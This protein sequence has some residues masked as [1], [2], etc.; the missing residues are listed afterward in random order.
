MP[1]LS[2]LEA[3]VLTI[4][5]PDGPRRGN[6]A[7]QLESLGIGYRF[8][9][10]V[11]GEAAE[12]KA[13]YS[14]IRNLLLAK[15]S[16]TPGEIAVYAG[17]RRAWRHLVSTGNACA[18]VLEDDFGFIDQSAF[19]ASLVDCVGA[20][21]GWDIVKFFDFRP[22]PIVSRASIGATE[23]ASYKYP[24][25]GAVAYLI[26]ATAARHLLARR[27]IFRPVDEDFAWCWPLAGRIWSVVPNPVVEISADLGGST[28]EAGRQDIKKRDNPVRSLWGNVIQGVKQ[29]R[30][31]IGNARL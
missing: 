24:A 3:L 12:A 26:N 28:L 7:R 10:G 5:A 13:L 6:A 16:L 2:Q 17:H 15:R 11:D 23:L 19:K 8:I 20:P 27:R 25:S 21:A 30:A 4:D 14:P 31:M 29:G 1:E 22:K 18:L 9:E